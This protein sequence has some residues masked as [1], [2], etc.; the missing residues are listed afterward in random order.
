MQGHEDSPLTKN[1]LGQAKKMANL[2]KGIKFKRI[3][4]SDLLRAKRTAEIIALEKK[5]AIKTSHLLRER[6][7]GRLQGV[8][9]KQMRKDLKEQLKGRDKLSKEER[10][11]YKIV[12]DWESDEEL[13][14]RL[15]TFLRQIAVAHPGKKILV[16]T[17]GGV[18][19]IFLIHLGFASY[20]KLPSGSIGNCGQVIVDSDGTDFFVK[21]VIGVNN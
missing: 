3:F 19:R 4:S 17:H 12:R 7:L 13:V 18:M 1:G 5:M 14:I 11:K 8:K 16:V 6:F 9:F 10:F 21:E 15:I 2:L 20:G